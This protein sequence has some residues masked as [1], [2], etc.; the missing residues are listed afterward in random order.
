MMHERR[1]KKRKLFLIISAVV[2]AAI[3]LIFFGYKIL[4]E[5]RLSRFDITAENLNCT[6]SDEIK[7]TLNNLNLNY[8]GFKS[9][10]VDQELKKKFICIGQITQEVSYPDKLKLKITGREG[11][12]IVTSINP[13]IDINPQ[14][15]LSLEQLNATQSTTA[16]FP[17]RILNQILNSYKD[18]SESAYFIADAEGMVFEEASGSA[19]LPKLSIFSEELTVGRYV[20]NDA[21]KKTSEILDKISG[22]DINLENLLIVGDR[23]IIDSTPRITFALNRALDRQAASLQLILRQAKMNLDPDSRDS[24]SVESIDLRFDRPVVVYSK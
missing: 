5:N 2:I 11:K 21:V 19:L 3:L 18:A 22:F 7:N 20:S 12:F 1:F 17:P 16:A 14:I 6:N 15:V 9:G 13:D 24:R 8:F 10:I 23:L 4:T